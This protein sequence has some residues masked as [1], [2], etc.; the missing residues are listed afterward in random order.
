M[1]SYPFEVNAT[2]GQY[3]KTR[4]WYVKI[5]NG[6]LLF[7]IYDRFYV[8]KAKAISFVLEPKSKI[9][10]SDNKIFSFSDCTLLKIKRARLLNDDHPQFNAF[11]RYLHKD[12][13]KWR[14]EYSYYAVMNSNFKIL[15]LDNYFKT[16]LPSPKN[17]E[18]IKI[19]MRSE[20]NK[21]QIKKYIDFLESVEKESM[22]KL[23]T[24]DENN[25][26]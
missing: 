23:C 25:N 16:L 10:D 14:N 9:Y 2:L 17:A 18:I 12:N 26:I 1:K 21:W 6:L 4:R 7:N 11:M 19:Y 13:Y 8:V 24:N 22:I 3:Q 20:W 15:E 5:E